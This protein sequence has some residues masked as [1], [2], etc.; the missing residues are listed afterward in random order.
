MERVVTLI[1]NLLLLIQI[2]FSVQ[3]KW[4]FYWPTLCFFV[5]GNHGE[6]GLCHSAL[7]LELINKIIVFI[8]DTL[9]ESIGPKQWSENV[10]RHFGNHHDDQ[11]AQEHPPNSYLENLG[12]L[13]N[14]LIY[15]AP[16]IIQFWNNSNGIFYFQHY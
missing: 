10:L 3:E 11:E 14:Y 1:L 7:E 16:H 9:L 4:L 8:H 2:I 15:F 13:D 6:C 12:Y 5:G